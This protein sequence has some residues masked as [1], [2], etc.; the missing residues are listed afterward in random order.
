MRG[1]IKGSAL[2][3]TTLL[4]T[5]AYAAGP[6]VLE[7]TP[8][9]FQS[10][11]EFV[12]PGTTMGNQP[13]VI[14]TQPAPALP[15]ALPSA[16]PQSAIDEAPA[17]IISAPPAVTAQPVEPPSPDTIGTSSANFSSTMWADTPYQAATLLLSSLSGRIYSS[18]L[19]KLQ[20]DILLA[21]ATPPSGK[22]EGLNDLRLK[23]LY[24]MGDRAAFGTL[25]DRLPANARSNS[26]TQHRTELA[27]LSN[28]SPY[29]D[30]CDAVAAYMD[31]NSSKAS[32]F[33]QRAQIFCFAVTN[34]SDKAQFALSLL[35]DE[36][37]DTLPYIN[38][39]IDAILRKDIKTTSTAISFPTPLSALDAVMLV[40]SGAAL[41][42]NATLNSL[43][44]LILATLAHHPQL[45]GELR[46]QAAEQAYLYHALPA[47]FLAKLYKETEA[48]KEKATGALQRAA[49]YQKA[50]DIASVQLAFMQFKKDGLTSI[51]YAILKDKIP[52]PPKNLDSTT[53][54]FIPDIVKLYTAAG[55]QAKARSWF[56]LL[57]NRAIASS[58]NTKS[59][60]YLSFLLA[61]ADGSDLNQWWASNEQ[62]NRLKI[63]LTNDAILSKMNAI[64]E[65]LG[66]RPS[67]SNLSAR[68][69]TANSADDKKDDADWKI[70]Y[71]L[72]TLSPEDSNA[73]KR[74]AEIA[75]LV[76]KLLSTKTPESYDTNLLRQSLLSLRSIGLNTQARSLALEAL[77]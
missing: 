37:P 27:F 33:W 74:S 41:P 56:S 51:A 67:T 13:G 20:E 4:T 29:K 76:L 43:H 68:L 45:E 53:L 40:E 16:K 70:I 9:A 24:K 60:A 47:D 23:A 73:P 54:D 12:Q 5:S 69:Y 63:D 72:H 55:D 52:T 48:P 42:K 26:I 50:N 58:N 22:G 65:G 2:L 11:E 10:E 19:Y 38:S 59:I 44:P 31:A 7:A 14:E 28:T 17:A 36:Y 3:I 30:A 25:Y 8:E 32:A 39:A 35:Q 1:L 21:S 6:I 62:S 75:L 61:L 15:P 57:E 77:L 18:T 64:M 66:Y 46:L 34:Q 71:S 49:L